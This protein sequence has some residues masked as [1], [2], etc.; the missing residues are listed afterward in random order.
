[1]HADGILTF[2]QLASS[3]TARVRKILDDAGPRFRMHSPESWAKQAG[4]A[5]D[6][7]W[8]AL[9]KLQDALDGGRKK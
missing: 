3:K 5:A 7:K 2:K 4:L 1:L 9:K 6:G 8:D